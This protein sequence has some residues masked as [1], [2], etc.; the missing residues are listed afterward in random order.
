MKPYPRQVTTERVA[1][2]QLAADPDI[3][4]VA[5]EPVTYRVDA[6]PMLMGTKNH[7]VGY[8]DASADEPTVLP[9]F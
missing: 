3:S 7:L 6:G 8:F 1:Q 5:R 4:V 2:R 9:P